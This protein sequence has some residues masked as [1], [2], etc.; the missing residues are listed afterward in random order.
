MA[1][2]QPSPYLLQSKRLDAQFR[3]QAETPILDTLNKLVSAIEGRLA[4]LDVKSTDMD[5]VINSVLEIALTRMDE[6][7]TPLINDAEAR[8]SQFGAA[9]NAT[10]TTSLD[11]GLGNKSVV[12]PPE[13][14]Q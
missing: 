11:I 10:S 13:Q 14:R 4:A 2:P 9:F 3:F 6:T 7:F 5:A 8:L 1:A 12:L